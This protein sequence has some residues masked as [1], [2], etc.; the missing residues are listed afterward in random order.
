MTSHAREKILG[1]AVIFMQ[2]FEGQ[3]AID[4]GVEISIF[5]LVQLSE[6]ML[7][8]VNLPLALSVLVN[9][10]KARL[11]AKEQVKYQE[12]EKRLSIDASHEM[13]VGVEL[14][15]RRIGDAE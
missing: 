14:S 8:S 10:G 9:Q 1:I 2:S 5:G 13:G 15:P 12:K 6:R 7:L 11:R 4:R 3:P